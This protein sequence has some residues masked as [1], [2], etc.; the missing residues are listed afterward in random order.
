MK[1]VLLS[2]ASGFIAQKAAEKLTQAG[3]RTIGISH[4]S[5]EIPHFEMVYEG[6]LSRSLTGVFQENIDVFVH[7]A[8]HSGEDDFAINVEGTRL[9]AQQAEK[10]GVM[11]QIFLSS[12]SARPDSMSSYSRAKHELEEWFVGRGYA[13][14]RMGLVLGDGGLFQRMIDLVRG[15]PVLPLLDGGRSQ[16]YVSGIQDVC[17]ALLIA[18]EPGSWVSGKAWNLFQPKPFYLREI[19]GEIKKQLGVRCLFIPIPSWLALAVVRLL[20][21]IPRIKLGISSNN[22]IGL[23]QNVSKDWESDYVRFG[24]QEMPLVQLIDPAI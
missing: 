4:S 16:V 24:F 13:V 11:Q 6:I 20:E 10:N 15:A 17:K 8:Y 18:S 2:G 22:I 14:L 9:W 12:V 19:L 23:K 1:T 21:R 5:H 7:C 3:F